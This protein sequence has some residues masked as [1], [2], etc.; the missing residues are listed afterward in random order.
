MAGLVLRNCVLLSNTLYNGDLK[1]SPD[2]PMSIQ[3]TAGGVTDQARSLKRRFRWDAR[4]QPLKAERDRI[5]HAR[6]R[7]IDSSTGSPP[8]PPPGP[9]HSAN[10]GSAAP[11]RA[12][13]PCDHGMPVETLPGGARYRYT[14][15]R[16]RGGSAG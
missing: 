4:R 1:T 7:D 16:C 8:A 5:R 9:L 6:G 13:A 15:R 10:P 12:A 2:I 14:G 11:T 3:A